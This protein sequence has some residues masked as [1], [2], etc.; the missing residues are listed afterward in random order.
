MPDLLKAA[1]AITGPYQL[2]ALCVIVLWLIV[3]TIFRSTKIAVLSDSHSANLLTL[4]SSKTLNAILVVA[5]L[6]IICNFGVTFAKLYFSRP[7]IVD[8]TVVPPTTTAAPVQ[9]PI[10]GDDLRNLTYSLD[11]DPVTLSDGKIEFGDPD[12]ASGNADDVVDASLV[13]SV[14]GDLTGDGRTSAVAVLQKSGG[15]SGIFY[16]LVPVVRVHG[17]LNSSAEGYMLGDRLQFRRLQIKAGRVEVDVLMHRPSD[18]MATPTRL[19]HLTFTFRDGQLHCTSL[20]CSESDEQNLW[21]SPGGRPRGPTLGARPAAGPS[22]D[23]LKATTPAELAICG[24]PLLRLL[25]NQA[26]QLYREKRSSLTGVD[27]VA[28]LTEQRQWLRSR[29]IT[30]QADINCLRNAFTR[31]SA[32]LRDLH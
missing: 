22:F 30:C 25:D 32:Q 14:F 6:A 24:T 19:S 5:V 12:N 16:Y 13:Q 3:R 17:Q 28:L 20:P 2:V 7:S 4:L 23:C 8:H 29:D 26:A 11:G 15:G 1:V 21:D 18:S 10:S 9:A 31:R 27:R